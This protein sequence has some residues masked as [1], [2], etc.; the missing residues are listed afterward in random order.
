MVLADTDL[1]VCA[2]P[3]QPL[4]N[5]RWSGQRFR[6]P[7]SALAT[8]GFCQQPVGTDV[9]AGDAALQSMR[10]PRLMIMVPYHSHSTHKRIIELVSSLFHC[11]GGV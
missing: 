7:S 4:S 10:V 3:Q 5:A 6:A 11:L 1:R 8:E 2:M 9:E